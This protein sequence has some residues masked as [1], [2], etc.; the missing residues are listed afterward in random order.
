[1]GEVWEACHIPTARLRALKVMRPDLGDDSDIAERFAHEAIATAGSSDHVVETLDAGIDNA[2][3]LP[4]LAMEL[5]SGRDL[6][7]ALEVIGLPDPAQVWTIVRQIAAALDELHVRGIVHC[8][9]K[10]ANLFLAEGREGRVRV[11]V[12]DVGIARILGATSRTRGVG[13]PLF[14]AP[15]QVR[16][17][18]DPRSDLYALGQVGYT[19]LT[20]GLAYWASDLREVVHLPRF[21]AR[22]SQGVTDPATVRARL[23]G[24]ALSPAIDAWFARATALHPGERFETGAA[25]AGALRTALDLAEGPV[26]LHVWAKPQNP[27]AASDAALIAAGAER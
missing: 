27:T 21:L 1:M 22:L 14:M 13:W 17:D 9:L 3:G 15:E 23:S 11:K 5:L 8:D 25:L 18:V 6:R 2:T 12:L 26:D 7:A 20:G 19:L 16:G 4:F 24:V 10:P